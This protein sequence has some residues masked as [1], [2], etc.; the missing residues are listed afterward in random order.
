MS[1]KNGTKTAYKGVTQ[2]RAPKREIGSRPAM[3]GEY[4]IRIYFTDPKTGRA[5]E[6]E[7]TVLA[8]SAEA[9]FKVRHDW[10]RE[11]QNQAS[12][13]AQRRRKVADCAT[14]WLTW[15]KRTVGPST[16][17]TYESQL[18]HAMGA[19]GDNYFDRLTRSDIQAW[20]DAQSDAPE[21]INGR[22]RVFKSFC[23]DVSADMGLQNPA[24]RVKQVHVPKKAGKSPYVLSP[25]ELRDV[26]DDVRDHSEQWYPLI[27]MMATTGARFGAASALHWDDIDFDAGVI[28]LHRAHH[29]NRVDGT[30]TSI[31]RE[32]PVV[33]ELAQALRVHRQRLIR[34]QAAGLS[35]G[36][37]FPSDTGRYHT[38]S[39][40]DKPLRRASVRVGLLRREGGKWVGKKVTN[41]W[42]RHTWNNLL[43]QTTTGIVQRS[44]TGHVKE[45]MS[46]R[47][48]HVDL[49]EKR[50]ATEAAFRLV[51]GSQGAN[52]G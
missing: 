15:K 9:A 39:C 24:E 49:T 7:R 41:R 3:S 34:A 52:R 12:E 6:S 42:F 32:V 22:L 27:L 36:L 26:L 28:S 35:D 8:E 48:S 14:E 16:W 47:Y 40:T 21:T 50:V 38:P 11:V 23:R 1:R 19:L 4:T 46:E 43:R 51:C 44:I 17:E 20:R 30:K 29:R 18:Q 33:I 45:D 31:S 25:S 13:Q 10:R 5:R 37:V 2:I